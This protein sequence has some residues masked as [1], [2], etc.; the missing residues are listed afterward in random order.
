[1]I[2]AVAATALLRIIHKIFKRREKCKMYVRRTRGDPES[3]GISREN[4]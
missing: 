3:E 4:L 1:M 2:V